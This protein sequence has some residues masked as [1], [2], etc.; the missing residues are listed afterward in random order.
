MAMEVG[1]KYY[2]NGGGFFKGKIDNTGRLGLAVASDLRPCMQ[3][4]LGASIDTNKL[5]E[6]NHSFG[7]QLNYS[8]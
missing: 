2:S 7:L 4:I 8:A 1:A 3:L 6:N 5:A